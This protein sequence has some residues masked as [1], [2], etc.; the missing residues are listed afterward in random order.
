M[1]LILRFLEL[2]I[3]LAALFFIVAFERVI[4]LPI[5]LL[6]FSMTTIFTS[7]S[8]NKFIFF[9][10]ASFALAIFY[11]QSFALSFLIFTF[12]Y[13]G[14]IFGGHLIESNFN[15]FMLLLFVSVIIV[16]VSSGVSV[17]FW[18]IVQLIFGLLGSAVFL[19]KY[20]LV[21]YGFIG[22]RFVHS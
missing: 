15:R 20:F 6:T 1:S 12:F 5:F 22:K 11:Q 4:G 7:R 21:K 9:I 19:L 14:F 13:L 10:F 2:L 18:I 8:V 16:M 17:S 3:R